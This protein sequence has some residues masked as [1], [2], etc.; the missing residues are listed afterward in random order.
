MVK[1]NIKTS[2]GAIIIVDGSPSEVSEILNDFRERDERR[3]RRME[4]HKKMREK[5]RKEREEVKQEPKESPVWGKEKVSVTS[6]LRK[7]LKEGFFNEP[8]KFRD[9]ATRLQKEGIFV[10]SSTL[11]P[12]LSRLVSMK[13]LNREKGEDDLWEYVKK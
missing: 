10:P 12:I 5:W 1:A 4:F 13:K 9:V 8:K 2:S 3:I 7:F 11:H 6:V